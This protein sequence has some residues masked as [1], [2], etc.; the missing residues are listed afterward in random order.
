[1]ALRLID[2]LADDLHLQPLPEENHHDFSARVLYSALRFWMQAYCIDDGYGGALGVTQETIE[3]KTRQWIQSI[4]MTQSY[5]GAYFPQHLIHEYC[6]ALVIVGDLVRTSDGLLR[7]TRP[8]EVEIT[9]GIVTPLGLYDPSQHRSILTGA[10]AI[11]PKSHTSNYGIID[12]MIEP[13]T[14]DSHLLLL[15]E[16]EIAHIS[17]SDETARAWMILGTWPIS[18]QQRLGISVQ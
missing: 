18:N 6:S 14:N 2:V 12:S 7:C 8:H 17:H 3:Q 4:R 9:E 13:K 1:M 5:I 10:L 15:D 16:D 11:E